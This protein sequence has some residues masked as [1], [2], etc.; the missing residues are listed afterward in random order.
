MRT[1]MYE[2]VRVVSKSIC[3]F[4]W[5][6]VCMLYCE[7]VYACWKLSKEFFKSKTEMRYFF[8]HDSF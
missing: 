8:C 3:E 4:I 2:G 1:C 7:S 5:V 6:R